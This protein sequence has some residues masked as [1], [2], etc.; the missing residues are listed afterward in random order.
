VP[1]KPSKPKAG[2]Q[3]D[4][5]P[6]DDGDEEPMPFVVDDDGNMI[7]RRSAAKKPAKGAKRGKGKGNKPA[8]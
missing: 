5:S 4:A 3:F 2:P 7:L 6:I 1:R 8:Q